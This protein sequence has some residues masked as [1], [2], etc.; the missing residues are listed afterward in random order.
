M[1]FFPEDLKYSHHHIWVK[2]DGN[3]AVVGITEDLHDQFKDVQSLDLPM[4]AD[5]LELDTEC[6]TFHLKTGLYDIMSPLTGRI[7]ETNKQLVLNPSG[8]FIAPY[9][10]GWLFKM[11]YDEPEE[12]ELLMSSEEYSAMTD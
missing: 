12:L 4:E 10:D 5:E 6:M 2:P 3:V 9:T 11:E 7:V 1:A 8:I